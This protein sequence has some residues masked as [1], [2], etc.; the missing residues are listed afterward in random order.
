MYVSV[1][2]VITV[3]VCRHQ[4]EGIVDICISYDFDV[5][6]IH[7]QTPTVQLVRDM[8]LCEIVLQGRF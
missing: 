2:W 3:M 7:S 8:L 6:V 5:T 1:K 4:L